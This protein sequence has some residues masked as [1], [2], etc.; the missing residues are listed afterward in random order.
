VPTLIQALQEF[1][2]EA[3]IHLVCV[4]HDPSAQGQ[5]QQQQQPARW[6]SCGSRSRSICVHACRVCTCSFCS[7]SCCVHARRWVHTCRWVQELTSLQEALPARV[8]AALRSHWQPHWQA[9][10]LSPAGDNSPPCMVATGPW[11]APGLTITSFHLEQLQRSIEVRS[12]AG[13]HSVV[14]M[15]CMHAVCSSA[16]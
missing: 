14:C 11:Q 1:A 13:D 5:Q 9:E 8:A 3:H 7:R 15:S 10:E 12:L 6:S 2:S 16:S 4:M